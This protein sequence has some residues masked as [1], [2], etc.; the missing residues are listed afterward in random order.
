ML[1]FEVSLNKEQSRLTCAAGLLHVRLHA[2][3]VR[4][5]RRRGSDL[6]SHVADR[7]HTCTPKLSGCSEMRPPLFLQSW[8]HFLITKRTRAA[9]RPRGVVPV[10]EMESTPGPWYSTMAPVPPFTVRMPATFKM[11]SL[12]EVQPDRDPVSFTPITWRTKRR[13]FKRE[14]KRTKTENSYPPPVITNKANIE[15]VYSY[16]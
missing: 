2:V 3:V 4:E 6:G 7:C 16:K 14:E 5:H 12:G 10:H 13:R 11:T 9:S 1:L 8:L 15:Q